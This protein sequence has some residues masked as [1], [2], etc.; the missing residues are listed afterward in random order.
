MFRSFMMDQ[1][2]K[3]IAAR[4]GF[5]LAPAIK[6]TLLAAQEKLH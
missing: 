1:Y 4:G 3:Q 6:R 2:G 5:G